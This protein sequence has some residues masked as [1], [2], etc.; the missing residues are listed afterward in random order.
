MKYSGQPLGSFLTKLSLA[1]GKAGDPTAFDDY[2]EWIVTTTPEQFS[3]SNWECMDPLKIFPA[4]SV[5]RAAAEKL[6]SQ[7]NSAWSSLP[8]KN[9]FGIT[10][11]ES[12][13]VVIPAYRT[14]LCRELEKTN[15][16]GTMTLERP[17]YVRYDLADLHQGGSFGITLPDNSPATNG[18][19]ATIRWCDWV[20]LALANDKH[21]APFD[22]FAPANQ[23]DEALN[24]AK[25]R[26]RQ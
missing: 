2:A 12:D 6:F 18:V 22:P 8:W 16:C 20:A 25:T 10:T 11:V 9:N 17:G 13:L 3:Q 26:L 7:T 4:N 19:T 1:R 23:R 15:I 24:K 14:M 5:L 21:L